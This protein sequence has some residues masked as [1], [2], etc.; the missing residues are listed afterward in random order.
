MF[1]IFHYDRNLDEIVIENHY[2]FSIPQFKKLWARTIR[3]K[4]DSDGRE[5]LQNKKEFMYLYFMENLSKKNPFR[6]L[7]EEARHLEAVKA[8]DLDVNFKPDSL[9]LECCAI[10]AKHIIDYT[11]TLKFL[12]QMEQTILQM[13]RQVDILRKQ[14]EALLLTLENYEKPK[15]KED[16]LLMTD[17]VVNIQGNITRISSLLDIVNQMQ[18]KKSSLE[19]KVKDEEEALENIT[20]KRKLG[21]RENPIRL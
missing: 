13:Q 16:I 17:A 1:E 4:G 15:S 12:A 18:V 11:P 5:K 20:G 9:L 19:K 3:I 7:P 14:N 2:L 8:A 21:N 6:V 10:Y